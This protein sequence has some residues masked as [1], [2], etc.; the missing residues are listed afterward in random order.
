MSNNEVANV[1]YM[2]GF[3]TSR[4]P[5]MLT[6]SSAS[7][8][9][10]QSNQLTMYCHFY[11]VLGLNFSTYVC[12]VMKGQWKG[13][14]RANIPI[15]AQFYEKRA[16]KTKSGSPNSRLLRTYIIYNIYS[17]NIATLNFPG[18]NPDFPLLFLVLSLRQQS[19]ALLLTPSS[20]SM[21]S[22]DTAAPFA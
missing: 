8:L 10:L 4:P 20:V 13:G 14:S 17:F 2:P 18:Y 11:T 5:S 12:W 3:M 6:V 9:R 15:R 1:W 21:S 7:L 16:K 19:V 22:L